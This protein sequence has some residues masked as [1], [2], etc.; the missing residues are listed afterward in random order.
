MAKKQM[1]CVCPNCGSKD[2]ESDLSGSMIIWGGSSRMI[3]KNCNF[4]SVT[5]PEMDIE[6]YK[7]FKKRVEHRTE[8]EKIDVKSKNSPWILKGTL[9]K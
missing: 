3:C 2:V 6:G 9:M 5:F 8:K 7:E 4:S 1:F